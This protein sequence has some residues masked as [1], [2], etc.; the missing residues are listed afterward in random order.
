MMAPPNARKKPQQARAADEAAI[1][2][3][4]VAWSKAAAAKDLDKS[5][6]VYTDDAVQLSAKTPLRKGKDEIRKGWV[7][8]FAIPGPGLTFAPT[9]VE[10]AQVRRPGL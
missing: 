4:S 6:A 3:A 10:V 9:V 2:A 1:R 7:E 8:M 5:M